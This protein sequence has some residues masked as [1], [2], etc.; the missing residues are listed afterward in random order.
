MAWSI[1]KW[2]IHWWSIGPSGSGWS[3]DDPLVHLGVDDPLVIHWSIWE[4]MIH[5]WS[6]GPS[7]SGWSIG[8]PLVPSGIGWSIGDPLVHLGVDDP[9]VIHWSIWEW[10][11]HWWSIGHLR[12][13]DPL[14][15]HWSIWEWMIHWW[16]IGPSESGMILTWMTTHWSIWSWSEWFNPDP[17]SI[18]PD[19][20]DLTGWT[21]NRWVHVIDTQSIHSIVGRLVCM[22]IT[23]SIIQNLKLWYLANYLNIK[24]HQNLIQANKSRLK[25]WIHPLN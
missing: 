11:I 9:L 25:I 13:D 19:H 10:M 1:W 6:I 5:W 4:W 3:I 15:I 18:G 20:P 2:M 8:D 14:V 12:V 24:W 23:I 17:W 7:E 21:K 16:S 22:Y